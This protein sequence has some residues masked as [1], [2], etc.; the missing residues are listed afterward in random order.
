MTCL[1]FDCED[2]ECPYWQL[3]DV[4]LLPD[5]VKDGCYRHETRGKIL[6]L[7]PSVYLR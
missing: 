7:V 6:G 4:S 1:C 5:G 2:S 3:I